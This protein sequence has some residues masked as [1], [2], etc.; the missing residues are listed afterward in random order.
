M[1]FVGLRPSAARWTSRPFESSSVE[2]APQIAMR[3]LERNPPLDLPELRQILAP[4]NR[5]SL[6]ALAYPVHGRSDG[7]GT[8]RRDAD[9]HGSREMGSYKLWV[10]FLSLEEPGEGS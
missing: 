3:S 9:V 4:V 7:S 2:Q 6:S 1:R 5:A 8:V 10:L